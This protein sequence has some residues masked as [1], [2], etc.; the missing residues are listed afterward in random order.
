MALTA[1]NH[2]SIPSFMYGTAWKKDATT[3]L[4][5]LAVAAGFRAIDTANQLI[6]YQEAL[7]GEALQA[8]ATQGIARETLFLQTKF[9]PTNGQD[10]RTPYDASADLTMQ[11][12][13]SFDSSLIHLHTD[14]VD[15]YVLHGPYSRYTLGA[16]DR[17][18][19]AAMEALYQ[20]GKTKMIGIS[21]VTAL[22]L[23]QLCAEATVKPM[24]VQNRCYAALGWDKDVR[25][26]CRSQNIIYQ[27]F[28]LLT[29]NREV[30]ADPEMGAIAKRLGTGPAQVTFAFAMHV[31]MLP[32][33]GTTNPQHMKEDLQAEQLVL[34]S[35]D[36]QR[37]ETMGM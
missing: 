28:S 27:G 9:T 1:Y 30:L 17:E 18:V 22:Q 34:S 14:Y 11:V 29:A 8:L 2:A 12:K 33:T 13:Q 3:R 23:T 15:S 7:V 10:H 36:I 35:E 6:H 26:I 4:V 16:A 31:G 24:V 5:Q 25:G 19:W 37:I 20:A 21:N 32:L